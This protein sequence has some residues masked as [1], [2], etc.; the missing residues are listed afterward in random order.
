MLNRL[1]SQKYVFLLILCTENVLILHR[2]QLHSV[3]ATWP[4]KCYSATVRAPHMAAV[5]LVCVFSAM[6]PAS[7]A[8]RAILFALSSFPGHNLFINYKRDDLSTLDQQQQD[9]QRES[10]ATRDAAEHAAH[11]TQCICHCHQCI[12]NVRFDSCNCIAALPAPHD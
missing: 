7:S 4:Y 6:F 10:T 8:H 1:I 11:S 12:L 3:P 9:L 2:V 5:L